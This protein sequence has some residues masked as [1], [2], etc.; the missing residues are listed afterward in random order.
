M[1][2]I[3]LTWGGRVLLRIGRYR[4]DLRKRRPTNWW[5]HL[6]LALA[7]LGLAMLAL[8]RDPR[9]LLFTI[10]GSAIFVVFGDDNRRRR[11]ASN[12]RNRAEEHR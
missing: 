10:I 6:A 9:G 11:R 4:V 1:K 7:M 3:V 8:N 5:Q 12:S 2:P